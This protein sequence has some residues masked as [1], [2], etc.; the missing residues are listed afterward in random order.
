MI[1]NCETLKG[2]ISSDERSAAQVV[3][4]RSFLTASSYVFCGFSESRA[5]ASSLLHKY[6]EFSFYANSI[7][8]VSL[9]RDFTPE[10]YFYT[11]CSIKRWRVQDG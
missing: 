8:S 1:E 5:A 2:V 4:R 3:G 11:V 7:Y 9:I 6:R 10:K